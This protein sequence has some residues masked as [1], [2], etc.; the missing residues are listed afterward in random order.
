MLTT[1]EVTEETEEMTEEGEG[2]ELHKVTKTVTK[3][4]T[5]VLNSQA[6]KYQSIKRHFDFTHKEN[7]KLTNSKA[8]FQSDAQR[9]IF[10]F[11]A[12]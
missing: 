3:E 10:L 1:K 2:G 11:C 4:V 7:N 5:K 12:A 8:C 9:L 6:V